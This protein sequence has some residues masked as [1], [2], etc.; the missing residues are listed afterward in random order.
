MPNIRK[1]LAKKNI[2]LIGRQ[3]PDA[4]TKQGFRLDRSVP[5]DEHDPLLVKKGEAYYVWFFRNGN[6]QVSTTYPTKSQLTQSLFLKT[7]YC[8][9]DKVDAIDLTNVDQQSMVY[10]LKSL[11]DEAANLLA[12]QQQRISNMPKTLQK[13]SNSGR[14]LDE[15]CLALQD[16]ITRLKN[17]DTSQAANAILEAIK[18]TRYNGR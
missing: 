11:I 7:I 2:Y 10:W 17:I 1:R 18:L 14:M 12:D 13:S 4:T 15:R 6:R 3:I 16:W 5:N 9:E 8:L